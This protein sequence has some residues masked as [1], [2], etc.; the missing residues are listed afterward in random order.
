MKKILMIV[1]SHEDM[2]RTKSKTGLWIG[3]FTEPYYVFK[4]RG[5]EVE[6]ASPKGGQPPIDPMSMLTKNITAANRKFKKDPKAQLA[7][8]NTH[9]LEGIRADEFDALFLPGGH[10]PMWDLATDEK[11]GKLILDFVNQGKFVGAICHG[12]AALLKAEELQ[13]GLLNRKRITGFSD[14]EEVLAFRKNNIP[15]SLEKRLKAA[16]A[17]YHKSAFPFASHTEKDDWLITGQNPLAAGPAAVL[18]AE[19]I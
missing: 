13:P 19:T 15:Y 14:F 3:E 6:I 1:T 17:R 2:E 16:G 10:G 9:R 18:L 11:S 7:L 5:F 4:E 12:P 8:E